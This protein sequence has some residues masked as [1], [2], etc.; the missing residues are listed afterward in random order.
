MKLYHKIRHW[1]LKW[2]LHNVQ[3]TIE[4]YKKDGEKL[5]E[6]LEEYE[7]RALSAEFF[8]LKRFRK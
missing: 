7:E 2:E 1:Y 4:V 6:K 3:K 5:K 8:D